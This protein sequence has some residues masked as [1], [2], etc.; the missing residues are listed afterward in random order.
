M[1][2]PWGVLHFCWLHNLKPN[3]FH[4][5]I[6]ICLEYD[7]G[8]EIYLFLLHITY[9]KFSHLILLLLYFTVSLEFD[10]YLIQ[11]IWVLR[12]TFCLSR[13]KC[14]TAGWNPYWF[15]KIV[16]IH[17]TKIIQWTIIVCCQ[18]A[19]WVSEAHIE[20]QVFLP[21]II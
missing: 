1:Y 3:K 6:L 20:Q 8:S 14:I 18:N 2:C 17:R 16:T 10:L 19:I 21:T 4:L 15:A 5:S 9:Q 13:K 12:P 11:Q 7:I